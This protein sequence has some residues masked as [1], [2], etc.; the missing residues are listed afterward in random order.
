MT[1][2]WELAACC[3]PFVLLGGCRRVLEAETRATE[4]T[5]VA[6]PDT[7]G[8]VS[9]TREWVS[10]TSYELGLVR[11]GDESRR[12]L[13]V[14]ITNPHDEPH[15]IRRV[16]TS[17]G[18]V[19]WIMDRIRADQSR[20]Y[21]VALPLELAPR[22]S[23][24]LRMFP[25]LSVPPGLVS[26]SI[27]GGVTL[28]TT[29]AQTPAIRLTFAATVLR[30]VLVTPT[31]AVV[32]WHV[33]GNGEAARFS[34]RASDQSAF[35]ILAVAQR[36]A[37]VSASFAPTDETDRDWR[38]EVSPSGELPEGLLQETIEIRT[39]RL[40]TV[41]LS[42]RGVVSGALVLEPPKALVFG[43]VAAHT[44]ARKSVE[45]KQE[46]DFEPILDDWSV[47]GSRPEWLEVRMVECATGQGR[48]EI[49][50][51][52]PANLTAGKVD[53]EIDLQFFSDRPRTRRLRVIAV[54]D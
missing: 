7:S 41:R 49:A 15:S 18:C 42:L 20:D 31:P 6:N 29:D 52:R 21:D 19:R 33:D 25:D 48:I 45:V 4:K 26:R 43:R 2:G 36:P 23:C 51:H 9:Q 13:S 38:V 24:I 47:D 12:C 37:Y 22:A 40:D 14:V 11:E 1:R 17:C 28:T 16:V 46:G 32:D 8:R 30:D 5:A 34:I 44:R 35:K 27:D 50:V 3:L 53:A 54:L 10:S 39:D